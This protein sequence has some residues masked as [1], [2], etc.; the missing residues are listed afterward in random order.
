M[1]NS[2]CIGD[3]ILT[4]SEYKYIVFPVIYSF[5]IASGLPANIAVLWFLMQS[6]KRNRLNEAK[7][8]MINLTVADLLFIIGLPF[9][10]VY[11]IRQGDWIFS[12]FMCS[13]SGSLFYINTYN[14]LFFLALTSFSRYYAVSQPLRAAQ[15]KKRI[16][17]L[18]MS[19]AVWMITVGSSFPVIIRNEQ[20]ISTEIT[21][22]GNVSR[23]FEIYSGENNTVEIV[24]NFAMISAFILSFAVVIGCSAAILKLLSDNG[25]PITS[26]RGVKRQALRTVIVILIVFFICFIPHHVVKGPWVLIFLGTWETR[27]CVFKQVLNDFYQISFCIMNINCI[28]DPIVYSFLSR[29]FRNSVNKLRHSLRQSLKSRMPTPHESAQGNSVDMNV[30]RNN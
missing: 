20:Y 27:D 17:G 16:R 3:C 23:C 7:I 22:Y 24:L 25:I 14:S 1:E 19:S 28:L 18:V 4:K 11:Y 2:S 5:I 15:S 8:Y 6:C 9:W 30:R 12:S 10:I 29:N 21:N 13:L 26:Q